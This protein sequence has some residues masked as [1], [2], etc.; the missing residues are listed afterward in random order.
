MH[1]AVSVCF[2]DVNTGHVIEREVVLDKQRTL[3]EIEEGFKLQDAMFYCKSGLE[4]KV[5][6]HCTR[7]SYHPACAGWPGLS[8]KSELFVAKLS[9]LVVNQ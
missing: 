7:L 1:D 3:Q 6:A 5:Q 8:L 9:V 4:V 2:Y